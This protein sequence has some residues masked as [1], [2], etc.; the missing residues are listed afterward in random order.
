MHNCTSPEAGIRRRETAVPSTL[1]VLPAGRHC[2]PCARWPVT[3]VTE[4]RSTFHKQ[5]IRLKARSESQMGVR[6]VSDGTDALFTG[7]NMVLSGSPWRSTANNDPSAD[8]SSTYRSL[9]RARQNR[10]NR[11]TQ[12]HYDGARAWI[13]GPSRA[14]ARVSCSIFSMSD[15][16]K[17]FFAAFST[18]FYQVPHSQASGTL[19]THA[20][21]LVLKQ[22][23][24]LRQTHDTHATLPGRFTASLLPSIIVLRWFF[25]SAKIWHS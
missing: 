12:E 3:N 19:E 8:F 15:T 14:T 16:I 5:G 13:T 10:G 2:R 17:P 25:H 1:L 23:L 9:L 18:V 22:G 24:A 20:H 7:P 11:W 4:W 6:M 21:V